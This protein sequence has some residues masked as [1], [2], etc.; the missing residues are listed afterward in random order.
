MVDGGEFHTYI[1]Y[2]EAENSHLYLRRELLEKFTKPGERMSTNITE[3][4]GFLT[5]GNI[6]L[7]NFSK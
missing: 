6:V 7:H 3:V 4:P 5:F 2:Q 1:P